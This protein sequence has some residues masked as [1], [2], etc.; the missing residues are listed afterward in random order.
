MPRNRHDGT[1]AVI[2]HDIICNP[3]W[4]LFLIQWIYGEP[5]SEY[6]GFFSGGFSVQIRFF[7]GIFDVI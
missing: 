3:D 7:F 6:A 4:D 5:A 2:H 1:C